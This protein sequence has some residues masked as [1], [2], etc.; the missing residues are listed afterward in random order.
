MNYYPEQL[1]WLAD[2]C[3]VLNEF[4]KTHPDDLNCRM[5]IESGVKIID[6]GAPD[7]VF[8]T[9]VDEIGGVWSFLPAKP[10]PDPVEEINP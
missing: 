1:R 9:L 6:P 8:G 2:L 3:E 5:L 7:F 10:T 4:D